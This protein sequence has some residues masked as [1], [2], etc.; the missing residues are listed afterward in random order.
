M[1]ALLLATLAPSTARSQTAPLARVALTYVAHPSL[2]C[3]DRR[4][5]EERVQARLGRNPFDPSS[6][7]RV[8]V[9]LSPDPANAQRVG[10]AAQLRLEAASTAGVPVTLGS[11]ALHVDSA[12]ECDQLVHALA[13]IVAVLIDEAPAEAPPTPPPPPPVAPPPVAPPPAVPIVAPV[14]TLPS[15]RQLPRSPRSVDL[16]VGPTVAFGLTPNPALGGSLAVA[17]SSTHWSLRA[18]GFALSPLAM[19]TVGVDR[20]ESFVIGGGAA[21][22]GRVAPFF[23]CGVVQVGT[24]EATVPTV[25]TPRARNS[26]WVALGARVGVELPLTG[27]LF[28]VPHAELFGLP[29]K[30]EVVVAREVIWSMSPF[31]GSAG[32]DLALRFR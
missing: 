28:L 21:A 1:A 27:R 25:Q 32:V 2:A 30:V 11:R 13:A 16:S 24:F 18:E 4:V 5:L 22:C 20:I 9:A 3:P 6:S 23:A 31:V 17:F 8:S 26:L 12:Q 15:P 29:A 19:A 14:V 10:I 7:T